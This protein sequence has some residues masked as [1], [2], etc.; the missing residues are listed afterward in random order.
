MITDGDMASPVLARPLPRRKHPPL[1][2]LLRTIREN[3]LDIY[4]EDAFERDIVEVRL[5]GQRHFILSDPDGIKH[6]LVDNAES[7]RKPSIVRRTFEPGFGKGLLTS[8]GEPWRR[9]RRI[10]APAFDHRSITAY[11]PTIVEVAETIARRWDSLPDRAIIDVAEEMRDATLQIISRTMFSSDSDG[12][13]DVVKQA[14][15]RYNE[16]IR[17][18]IL[19]F[20]GLPDLV[21]GRTRRR[22]A[23]QLFADFDGIIDRL[24]AERRRSQSGGATDLLARLVMAT[25]DGTSGA[26]M[27][28]A[29]VRDQAI[30]IFMAGHDTTAL[31]LAWT[32]Y[33]LAQHPRHEAKLHSELHA[34]FGGRTPAHA[35]LG[36]LAYTRM[37]IEESMRL[38]P[39]VH[40]L[41]REATADDH[42]CGHRIP[43]KSLILIAPWVLH[44]HG[45]L[46]ED[47]D[48][49]Q[50]GRFRPERVAARS[51][52]SYLPFGAGPHVC[53]GAAFAMTE[54][55]LILA[56]LA[57]RFQLRLVSGHP[58]EPQGLLTLRP[59]YGLKMTLE[60]RP[61][62]KSQSLG[63]S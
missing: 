39:P 62:A 19:D 41:L 1:L 55:T 58:V 12:I 45:R 3:M 46:W 32:W 61:G 36:T 53:I 29:E 33:L 4:L 23:R 13:A 9:H 48:S 30:T 44:R 59:R 8:E 42:V 56:T 24:I 50:P 10:M 34:V 43:K 54:A 37:I 27:T 21:A 22:V 31:V 26:R 7:Y 28:S 51:R 40:L 20:V 11:S 63:P 17:P 49:F 5:L 35:D 2:K 60:R 16:K 52:F 18:N 6:V 14:V 47:P 15:E 25:D 38:Y 57:Q